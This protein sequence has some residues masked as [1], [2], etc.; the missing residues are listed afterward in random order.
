MEKLLPIEAQIR[1]VEVNP[2]PVAPVSVPATV[3]W[4]QHKESP[5][6]VGCTEVRRGYMIGVQLPFEIVVSIE[7]ED[8]VPTLA[9][10]AKERI[11]RIGRVRELEMKKDREQPRLP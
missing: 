5:V 6:R 2:Q 1:P 7:F 10:A 3:G 8:E 4:E 11:R 9:S